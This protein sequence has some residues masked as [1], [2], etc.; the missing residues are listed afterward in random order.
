MG[1]QNIWFSHP[2]KY[3]PGS[4]SWSVCLSF[5]C[6]H[7]MFSIAVRACFRSDMWLPL[8]SCPEN[9]QLLRVAG[10][11]L[12]DHRPPLPSLPPSSRSFSPPLSICGAKWKRPAMDVP[13]TTFSRLTSLP[14]ISRS[15]LIYAFLSRIHLSTCRTAFFKFTISPHTLIFKSLN[16]LSIYF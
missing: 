3:G 13:C 1:H 6:T 12:D 10:A 11:V 8:P 2:R 5:P 15:K 9:R 7:L 16:I 4:R 14:N